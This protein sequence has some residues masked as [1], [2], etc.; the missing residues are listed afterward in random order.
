MWKDE[1]ISHYSRKGVK[2]FQI[3][4]ENTFYLADYQILKFL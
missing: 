1:E 3:Q 2:S 4:I